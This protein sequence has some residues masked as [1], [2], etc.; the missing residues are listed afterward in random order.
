ME[1]VLFIRNFNS[2]KHCENA[3]TEKHVDESL[4]TSPLLECL[5]ESFN[6]SIIG[7]FYILWEKAAGH[8]SL[9]SVIGYT[10][11]AKTPLSARGICAGTFLQIIFL[12]TLT[13]RKSPFFK[14]E[15]VVKELRSK[16]VPTFKL[17]SF[18]TESRN[19]E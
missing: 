18:P 10:F 16:K 9:R 2:G 14:D 13:H 7:L 8:F 15:C 11:T 6:T 17:L 3:F 19:G 1:D 5:N 12:I 4:T